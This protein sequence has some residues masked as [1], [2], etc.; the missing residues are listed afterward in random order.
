MNYLYIYLKTGYLY[1][2]Y[3]SRTEIKYLPIDIYSLKG[4]EDYHHFFYLLKKYIEDMEIPNNTKVILFVTN[5]DIQYINYKIPKIEEKDLDD[6]LKFDL[7]DYGNLNMQDYLINY[8]YKTYNNIMELSIYLIPKEFYSKFEEIFDKF[9]LNLFKILPANRIFKEDGKYID[10]NLDGISFIEIKD[11]L[12]KK[13]DYIFMPELLGLFKNN[14][15]ETPNITNILMGKYDQINQTIDEDFSLKLINI[16]SNYK[17]KITSFTSNKPVF[18]TGILGQAD[19]LDKLDLN[20]IKYIYLLNKLENFS[21]KSKS[22]KDI[23]WKPLCITFVFLLL[24]F[25]NLLY[26]NKLDR[27]ISKLSEKINKK[28]IHEQKVNQD[29]SSDSQQSAN[30]KFLSKIIKIQEL[31]NKDLLFTDYI[32]GK[33]F[34]IVKGVTQNKDNLSVFDKYT[35]IGKNLTLEDGLYKFEIKLKND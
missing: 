24:I 15:L 19:I 27:D 2:K 25:A 35:I 9:K 5:C 11:G 28:P 23:N 7:E 12:W 20:K 6:F 4:I 29:L 26:I 22:K 16:L 31:E 32:Y 33:D 8:D 10:F 34:I 14:K 1:I 18:F 3:K 21:Y 17:N 30:E 13:F